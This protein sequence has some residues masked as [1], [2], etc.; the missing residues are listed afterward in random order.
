M[1]ALHFRLVDVFTERPFAGNQLAVLLD[2]DAVEPARMQAIAREFNFAE[3]T[4]VVA[5]EHPGCDMRVRIFTP[6][7]ELPM[8]GHP[9]IG[10]ALVLQA[11]A[12]IGERVTFEL[13]VGPTPV[14]IDG[15]RAEMR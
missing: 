11:E 6:D 3:T 10:T 14:S 1:A 4:F 12:R 5:S 7:E 9:T 8:A 15:R 13:G 2:A